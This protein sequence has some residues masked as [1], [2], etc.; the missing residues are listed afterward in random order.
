MAGLHRLRSAWVATRTARLNTVRGLLRELGIFIPVGARQVVPHVWAVVS[1][2]ASGIPEP[3]GAVL[4]EAA[5]EIVDLEERIAGVEKQL[6][7]LT[8]RNPLLGRLQTIPGIGLLTATALVASIGDAQRFPSGRHFASFLGLTPREQS[9]GNIRRLG[10]ITKR[11]DPYLRM[12][13]VHGARSVLHHAKRSAKQDTLR[14]WALDRERALGHNKAAVALANKL[15][16]IVWAVWNREEGYGAS[17]IEE[18]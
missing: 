11:G 2:P 6:K 7:A 1:E 14:T 18:A 4:M 3:L 8:A 16:R 13:L 9:S 12:L 15:A 5:R 10:R 17:R